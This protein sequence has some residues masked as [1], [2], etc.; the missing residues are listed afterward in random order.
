VK[1]NWT[2]EV[3]VEKDSPSVSQEGNASGKASHDVVDV[4]NNRIYFYS[5]VD[6]L[7][8]LKLNKTIHSLGITLCQRAAHTDTKPLPIELLIN[9]FGGSVFSGFAA[10][11]YILNSKV[12][13]ITTI[14]GCAASAATMM[15]VVGTHRK[16]NK[17]SFMLVHQLS[18]GMWGN[19]RQ[20]KDDMENCELLMRKI[21]NIYREHT[22]I[23]KRKMDDILKH[24]LW[25]D[26]A[27]CLKYG[28]VDE[29]V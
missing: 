8:V 18:S 21:K 15:S 29:I 16:M 25:W 13:V 17:N 26:A 1:Y 27:T 23:P 9:S 10:V 24:D 5:S 11:D 4:V 6:K 20:L 14:D 3:T 12:P 19:F 7:R 28:L 2:S 22:K